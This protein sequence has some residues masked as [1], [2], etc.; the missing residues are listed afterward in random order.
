MQSNR[1]VNLSEGVAPSARLQNRTGEFPR[2]R[3]LNGRVF[4]TDTV[5][6]SGVSFIMAMSVQQEFV[7]EFFSSAPTLG[8]DVIDFNDIRVL[9]EQFTPTAFPLLFAQQHSFHPIAHGVVLESLAPIEEI[10]IVGTGRA[11]D[12]DVLL[13][14][15]LAVFP[16][17]NFLAAELPTLSLLH[18][19]VFV[20]DPASSFVGVASLG[21]ASELEVEHV[22]TGMKGL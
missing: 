7:A 21:P 4:G 2:I 12:F 8:G 16:Q 22:V 11:F 10:A 18:M 1:V 13:D 5:D 6:T 15:R 17:R 3:L 14:V 9:K 19:P 20:R